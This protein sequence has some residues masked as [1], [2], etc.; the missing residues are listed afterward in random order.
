VT[1]LAV[2]MARDTLP[3]A[4][5]HSDLEKSILTDKWKYAAGADKTA[6]QHKSERERVWDRE[7][8]RLAYLVPEEDRTEEQDDAILK[9]ENP[10]QYRKNH[11]GNSKLRVPDAR[12]RPDL[13]E[14]ERT[15]TWKYAAGLNVNGTSKTA[16][17]HGNAR[18]KFR[19]EAA[20]ALKAEQLNGKVLTGPEEA[21]LDADKDRVKKDAAATRRV[22]ETREALLEAIEAKKLKG[23]K[24]T[25]PEL[26]ALDDEEARLAKDVARKTAWL[27]IPGNRAKKNA[28][29]I[30]HHKENADALNAKREAECKANGGGR[31]TDYGL[32][33]LPRPDDIKET[34]ENIADEIPGVFVKGGKATSKKW[35]DDHGHKSMKKVLSEGNHLA[36]ILTTGTDITSGIEIKCP[37]TT[38][39]MTVPLRDPL[40]RIDEKIDGERNLRLFTRK[41]AKTVV[42]SYLLKEC[43]S[44]YDATG[45][46]G[47]LQ[48]YLEDE[49]GMPHGMYLHQKAGAGPLTEYGPT[50]TKGT[51]RVV[52]SIIRITSPTFADVDPSDPDRAPPLTSCSVV[53]HNGKQ[54]YNVVVRGHK[55]PF[56]DTKSVIADKAKIKRGKGTTNKRHTEERTDKKR[57]AE[58]KAENG[59]GSKKRKTPEP[60]TPGDEVFEEDEDMTESNEEEL[61]SDSESDG[62]ECAMSRGELVKAYG[63]DGDE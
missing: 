54:T 51:C 10:G 47:A 1:R 60:G 62:D 63:E 37:E 17:E 13:S 20:K 6:R 42:R 24:L 9:V 38:V 25:D 44:G 57:K 14:E 36:Y 27:E 39:F 15:E 56:P 61:P 43:L 32:G 4:N 19:S 28:A 59:A 18:Q 50:I 29:S 34:V 58:E 16:K 12:W 2:N 53:S 40:C 52:L 33:D 23:I 31:T 45:I 5:W 46:E 22:R 55:Q 21:A 8:M 26:E 49:L 30:A 11:A 35:V 48:R 41:E 7:D 3:P